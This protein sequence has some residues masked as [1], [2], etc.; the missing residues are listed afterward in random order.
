MTS[1]EKSEF[2]QRTRSAIADQSLVR[3]HLGSPRRESDGLSK[4]LIRP[5][6]LRGQRHLT[7]VYRH[8]TRDITRNHLPDAGLALLEDLMGESFESAFLSTTK[9]TAQYHHRSGR[10]PR[11]V[12]G[13]ATESAPASTQH[14][15]AR[16]RPVAMNAP[17]MQA[18]GLVDGQGRV[19]AGR[20]A[21]VRQI[22]RFVELLNHLLEGSHP[23]NAASTPSTNVANSLQWSLVDMGCGKGYLTFAAHQYL[24]EKW[25]SHVRTLGV[26]QRPDLVLA[27]N[28]V[29]QSMNWTGLE[30]RTGRIDESAPEPGRIL[31]ALHACDTATDDALIHGVTTGA[32][33]IVV[34]PCCHK[35]IRSQMIEPPSLA[36]ALTHGIL[37]E[38][39]AE[40][41]T[42][43]LRADLLQ[44]AGYRARV[45]EFISPDHTAKNLMITGVRNGVDAANREEAGKRVRLMAG[46]FGIHQ[47]RLAAR[48]GFPLPL[49]LPPQSEGTDIPTSI[50]PY[51]AAL[52]QGAS[53]TSMPSAN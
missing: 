26:E 25:G 50:T 19:C 20:E 37:R 11:L 46:A 14:D 34:A 23:Q 4:I 42:D 53:P 33:W 5:I 29:S 10:S 40:L 49:P 18:L 17:W 3:L 47:Q 35:E 2:I 12:V 31:V 7:F 1:P 15:R 39:Q 44:W 36:G 22:Q 24:L 6:E 13:K 52:H 27:A 32:D 30:F 48:L 16:H 38:R 21:K 9:F 45:F 28:K 51:A 8:A 43:A 41:V